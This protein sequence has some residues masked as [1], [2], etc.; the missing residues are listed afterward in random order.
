MKLKKYLALIL[1]LCVIGGATAS[2]SACGGDDSSSGSPASTNTESE[3][4]TGDEAVEVEYT[5]TVQDENGAGVEDVELVISQLGEEVASG[6]TDEDGKLTGTIEA[7]EYTVSI[8]SGTLP[9]GHI[10]DNYALTVNFTEENDTV[11]FTV[12]DPTPDGSARKP[13]P[14]IPDETG[15][16]EI[17]LPASATVNYIIYRAMGRSLVVECADVEITCN[18]ETYQPEN[19]KIEIQLGGSAEDINTGAQIAVK[20]LTATEKELKMQL[21]S[22]LGTWEN[23]IIVT[24]LTQNVEVTVE[25]KETVYLLYTATASGRLSYTVNSEQGAIRL[26]NENSYV[27]TDEET[28]YLDLDEGDLIHIN[29]TVDDAKDGETY[30]VSF[31]LTLQEAQNG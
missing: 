5:I 4:D 26:Y 15:A 11:D 17:T 6:A 13:Y 1:S 30:E 14:F 28:P 20:N 8:V 10:A 24:D 25:G 19:G 23:P 27:M 7:G 12:I 29:V 22:E 21:V 2:L 18:G 31:T 9:E 16:M 3:S